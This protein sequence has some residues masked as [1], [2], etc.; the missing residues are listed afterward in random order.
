MKSYLE[1]QSHDDQLTLVRDAVIRAQTERLDTH[2]TR[3]VRG[4]LSVDDLCRFFNATKGVIRPL[5]DELMA[6][7]DVTMN[8]VGRY[9]P[10]PVV[11]ESS[12]P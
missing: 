9:I 4:P 6:S 8:S 10:R 2:G 1:R 7:S 5:I 3:D 11:D 12:Q